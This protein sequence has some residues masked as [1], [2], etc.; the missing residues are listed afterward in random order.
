MKKPEYKIVEI[1][2]IDAQSGFGNAEYIEDLIEKFKPEHSFSA[3]YLIYECKEYI[4]LGF[5]LFGEE[6]V[7]HYQLIP[8]GMIKKVRYLK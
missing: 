5:M 4:L 6:S 7:K 1:D 8:Q 2:W 3:G